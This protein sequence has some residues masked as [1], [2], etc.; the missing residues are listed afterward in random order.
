MNPQEF[1]NQNSELSK[2]KM[3]QNT[4]TEL[5]NPIEYLFIVACYYSLKAD[6]K[7]E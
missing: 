4:N 7:D 1:L 6:P 5:S 2:I 3:N